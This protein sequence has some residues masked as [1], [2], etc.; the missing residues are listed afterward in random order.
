MSQAQKRACDT[1]VFHHAHSSTC[2]RT[3]AVSERR[4]RLHVKL[5]GRPASTDRRADAIGSVT[6]E[7]STRGARR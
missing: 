2:G 5:D 3:A 1:S 7:H 6:G 4:H